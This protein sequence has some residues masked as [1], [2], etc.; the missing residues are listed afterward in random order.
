MCDTI[1]TCSFTYINY[2]TGL[3]IR[4]LGVER[5]WEYLE[6]EFNRKSDGLSDAKYYEVFG[7]GPQLFAVVGTQ[8]YYHHDNKWFPY[9]SACD[10]TYGILNFDD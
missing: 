4:V 7:P 5:T 9:D 10:I 8:V 2:R 1:P 3:P 6:E